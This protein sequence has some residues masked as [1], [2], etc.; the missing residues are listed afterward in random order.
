MTFACTGYVLMANVR[1]YPAFFLSY[2]LVAMGTAIM[3]LGQHEGDGNTRAGRDG[4]I[5]R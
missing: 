4:A 5:R 2:L 3:G 1:S